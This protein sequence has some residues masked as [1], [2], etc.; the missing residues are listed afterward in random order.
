MAHWKSLAKIGQ[1][2]CAPY[3][4][5]R[6]LGD[7]SIADQMR[8]L[9]HV[10]AQEEGHQNME[11]SMNAHETHMKHGKANTLIDLHSSSICAQRA[12]P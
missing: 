10:C 8:E 5:K 9:A 11:Y 7:Q 2:T 6:K 3:K 1:E 4:L 12:H